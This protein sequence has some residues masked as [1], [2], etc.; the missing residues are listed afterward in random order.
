[1]GQAPKALV[2]L[3]IAGVEGSAWAAE[4]VGDVGSSISATFHVERQE[5]HALGMRRVLRAQLLQLARLH[6]DHEIEVLE[7]LS[8]R[9]PGTVSG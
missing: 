5:Y 8:S 3:F 9:R 4:R 2:D 7:Q 6:H 1:M